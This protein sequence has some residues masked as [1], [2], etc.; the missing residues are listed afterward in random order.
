[1]KLISQSLYLDIYLLPYYLIG[2]V[3]STS[4]AFT[5]LR[6]AEYQY[7]SDTVIEVIDK[8]QDSEMALPTQ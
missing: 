4:I 5:Y 2:I 7:Y 8:A 6:Y 1:M 3:V